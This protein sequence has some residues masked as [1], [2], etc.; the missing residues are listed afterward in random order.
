MFYIELYDPSVT[1][2]PQINTQQIWGEPSSTT[3]TSIQQEHQLQDTPKQQLSDAINKL[4]SKTRDLK[5]RI[6]RTMVN[7]NNEQNIIALLEKINNMTA[8]VT[9]ISSNLDNILSLPPN[10]NFDTQ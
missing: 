3:L 1:V 4:A 9:D 5:R 6:D 2:R 8:N 10:T 7:N